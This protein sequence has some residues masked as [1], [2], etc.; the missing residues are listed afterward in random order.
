MRAGCRPGVSFLQSFMGLSP[1]TKA[2]SYTI[3][4]I[5][6]REF[7]IALIRASKLV[8]LHKITKQTVLII[9]D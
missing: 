4:R 7:N 8:L 6:I 2:S 9:S 5:E 1:E 3:T